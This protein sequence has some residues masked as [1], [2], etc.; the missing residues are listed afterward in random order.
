MFAI[1]IRIRLERHKRQEFLQTFEMLSRAYCQ[2]NDSLEQI[3]F[4]NVKEPNH[5]LWVEYWNS[6]E[7]LREHVET[8][9]HYALLGVIEVLGT[10]E[11]LR[12]VEVISHSGSSGATPWKRLT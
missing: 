2:H 11:D 4:E 12:I 9:S 7:R 6:A 3:L 10:L 1:E 5:F 8:D